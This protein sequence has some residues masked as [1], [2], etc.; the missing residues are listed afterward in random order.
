MYKY[1]SHTQRYT[2]CINMPQTHTEIHTT[3]RQCRERERERE[4]EI[5]TQVVHDKM[6]KA[7]RPRSHT[8]FKK[9][10]KNGALG[11]IT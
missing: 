6:G 9:D 4:R 1:A 10:E 7:P 5:D 3:H 11:S 2:Q 8:I